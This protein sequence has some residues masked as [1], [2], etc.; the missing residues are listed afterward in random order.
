MKFVRWSVE[1]RKCPANNYC[2]G[3]D[4]VCDVFYTMH[5]SIN[6]SQCAS[7]DWISSYSESAAANWKETHWVATSNSPDIQ[8]AIPEALYP[9]HQAHLTASLRRRKSVVTPVALRLAVGN[10]LRR[11]GCGC[12]LVT[13]WSEEVS[14]WVQ[15]DRPDVVVVGRH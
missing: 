11:R 12:W 10:T 1:I 9:S 13:L 2:L 8:F 14:Q 6:C 4:G 15:R 3:K 7:I 5:D